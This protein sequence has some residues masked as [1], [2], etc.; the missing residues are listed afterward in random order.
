MIPIRYHVFTVAVI[1]FALG[2][3]ILLGGTIGQSWLRFDEKA[4]LK[5]VENKYNK[6][7]RN[8]NELKKQLSTLI[9]QMER[10][11]EE[12]IHLLAAAY[13]EDLSG[14]KVYV[15][16]SDETKLGTVRRTLALLGVEAVLYRPGAA[17]A[18]P[19]LIFA[20]QLPE[21]SGELSAKW[22][23]A[24]FTSLPETPAMQGRLLES[25][26]KLLKEKRLEREKS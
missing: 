1:F 24:Q 14:Q 25:L 19:L 3:G 10:S 18:Y 7:L 2:I 13:R 4:L 20:P 6:V 22:K 8:N 5:S 9:D 16:H 12:V 15:W 11:N 21:W 26:Q 23:W 17:A